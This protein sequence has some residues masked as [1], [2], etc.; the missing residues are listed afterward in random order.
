MTNDLLNNKYTRHLDHKHALS[1]QAEN[2]FL[3]TFTA[4][5]PSLSAIIQPGSNDM[6]NLNRST[7]ITA[8]LN[9]V[10]NLQT[11]CVF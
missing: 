9:K 11:S 3:T 5:D 4:L 8:I 2:G 6:S 10:C 7:N 1:N